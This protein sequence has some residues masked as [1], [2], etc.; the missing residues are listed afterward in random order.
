[1]AFV[2]RF[3]CKAIKKIPEDVSQKLKE[4]K[5]YDHQ[6]II[7]AIDL[8]KPVIIEDKEYV[9]GKIY[10]RGI[11]SSF[12]LVEENGEVKEK[13]IKVPYV[14]S[15]IFFL[16]TNSDAVLFSG[17]KEGSSFGHQVISKALFGDSSSVLP[18]EFNLHKIEQSVAQ[19]EF[20]NLWAHAYKRQ[21]NIK[22]RIEFG[23]N[24]NEDEEFVPSGT[25]DKSFLGICVTQ[26]FE[27]MKIKVFRSG[28]IMFYKNWD[29]ETHIVDVFN[30]V[31]IFLKYSM[32][33]L[34]L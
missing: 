18:I 33:Q 12:D 5:E 31:K 21:G 3:I 8:F 7:S 25:V 11:Q 16:S 2:Y 9:R 19:G 22:S 34:Q 28:G 29:N 6:Q 1:M 13:E 17:I 20:S 26:D 24:I 27:E 4:Y 23:E 14:A 30:L 15:V 10:Y 32:T